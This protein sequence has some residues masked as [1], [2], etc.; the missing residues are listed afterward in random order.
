MNC[1]KKIITHIAPRK[2]TPNFIFAR[3]SNPK[4]CLHKKTTQNVICTS[5]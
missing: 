4:F 2:N 5:P 3:K 1:E